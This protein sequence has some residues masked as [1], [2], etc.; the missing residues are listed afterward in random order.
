M[1]SSLILKSL[2]AECPP[3]GRGEKRIYR[4]LIGSCRELEYFE[5]GRLVLGR[6]GAQ[7]RFDVSQRMTR[8]D[9]CE[10]LCHRDAIVPTD[11]DALE[12]VRNHLIENDYPC[13]KG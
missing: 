6:R 1:S 10:T 2:V 8:D 12:I 9:I 5:L 4:D 13:K 11:H 3:D 7:T